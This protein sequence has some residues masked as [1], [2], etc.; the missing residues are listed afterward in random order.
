M[1]LTGRNG[2]GKSTLI[3]ALLGRLPLAHGTQRIGP[4]V[5]IGELEQQRHLGER[6]VLDWFVRETALG[7]TEARS[8]LAK[9]GIG[10]DELG[11]PISS[12]SPGERTRTMLATFMAAG[13]NCLVLDEPTNHLDMP[14]I[15]Q[16]EQALESYQGTLVLVSHDRR[17]AEN[18]SVTRVLDVEALWPSGD[19]KATIE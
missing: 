1:R 7:L 3:D 12:L 4:A 15:E 11:R 9:F 18:V 13:V 2:T 17:F 19:R 14:A 6:D 5:V 16:L 8:L 10:T